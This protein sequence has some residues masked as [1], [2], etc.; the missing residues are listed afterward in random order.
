MSSQHTQ[1]DP[2]HTEYLPLDQIRHANRN[3]KRHDIAALR[4]AIGRFGFVAPPVLDER[5]GQLVAGHG[6]I[7]ALVEMRDA[8]EAPPAGVRLAEDGSWL[9]PVLRGWSSRSDNE[10]AAYLV[11]DNRLTDLG[12]WSTPDLAALLSDLGAADA[13][14]L[15]AAGYTPG[16]VDDLL[17][18]VAPPDLDDLADEHGDPDPSDTWPVVRVK[19]PPH[20]AAAWRSHLDAYDGDEVVAFAAL[21]DVDPHNP[22]ASDWTP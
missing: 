12:G 16:E 10:A 7:E 6:R 13:E 4:K 5:T 19:V 3:P 1:P 8:G 21:L 14:L 9:V 17:K 18:L 22:P 2:R 11:A 20:V 15:A